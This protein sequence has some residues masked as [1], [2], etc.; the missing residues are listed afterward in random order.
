MNKKSA[1]FIYKTISS[2]VANI[3]QNEYSDYM[4]EFIDNCEKQNFEYENSIHQQ[5]AKAVL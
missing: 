2:A 3:M 5:S 1:T 4:K